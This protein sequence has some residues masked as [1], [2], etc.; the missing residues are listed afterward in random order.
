MTG[1]QTCALPIS[2]LAL[3]HFDILLRGPLAEHLHPADVD[4][5]HPLL[6]DA[7][8]LADL[9]ESHF[10]RPVQPG[11]HPDHFPRAGV[12]VF[13][14]PVDPSTGRVREGERTLLDN[15][16]ILL[17]SSMMTGNHDNDQLP[18]VLLGRAGGRLRTGRVHDYLQSPNR[19]MCRDRK[20]VV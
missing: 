9:L 19:K 15:S 7:E 16:M 10:L 6:R 14:Q 2:Q 18:V 1:V 8:V 5:P 11:A 12:E 3:R 20:S 4:L 17:T 13:E